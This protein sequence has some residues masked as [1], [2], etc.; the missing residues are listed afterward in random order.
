MA[1]RKFLRRQ[2]AAILNFLQPEVMSFYPPTPKTLTYIQPN[3]KWIGWPVA[4]KYFKCEVG[5]SSVLNIYTDLMYS[6]SM[7]RLQE[8]LFPQFPHRNL[9]VTGGYNHI[10]ISYHNVHF[11]GASSKTPAQ[12][13]LNK[14]VSFQQCCKCSRGQC[15]ITNASWQAVPD[16]PILPGDSPSLDHLSPP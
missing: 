14:Q 4:E 13:P 5:R 11:W 7:V 1:I 3:M 12:R 2:P 8:D 15:R 16:D 6:S 10:I 9:S